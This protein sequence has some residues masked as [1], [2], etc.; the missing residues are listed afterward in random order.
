MDEK[1]TFSNMVWRFF[2]RVGA[3]GIAFIVSI[4]LARVL[5]PD[6]YGT[7]A[8]VTVIISIL[9]VFVDS[10]FGTSLIQKKYVN[11]LDYSSVFYFNILSCTIIYLF[12]FF[13]A[14]FISRIYN[15]ENLILIIRVMS[16]LLIISGIKNIQQAYIT[17]NMMFKKFFFA[18]LGGT[19]FAGIIGIMLAINGAGVWAL[20]IQMLSN[21]VV[22]TI[23]LWFTVGW[24]PCRQFSFQ[25]IKEL[26]RYSGSILVALLIARITDLLNQPLI[27][28]FYSNSDLAYYNQGYRIINIITENVNTAMES[29]LFP[30]IS[31]VQDNRERVKLITK[32]SVKMSCYV[33]MPMMMGIAVCGKAMISLLFTEK[34]LPCV[35]YMYVFC[36]L[37]AIYPINIANLNVPKALGISEI[38]IKYQ[39]IKSVISISILLLSLRFG[40]F[41]VAIGVLISFLLS[42]AVSAWPNREL[43]N[44]S[45]INEIQD[46][47]PII[48]LTVSMGAIVYLIGM[49]QFHLIIILIMQISMG[50]IV[51]MA[52]SKILNIDSYA[53]IKDLLKHLFN[54]KLKL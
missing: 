25:R 49:L 44:Y 34:W 5:S 23:I 32:K 28:L 1:K 38:L 42:T 36:V 53:I 47:I 7:V 10:G 12:I 31:R 30:T 46:V 20:I 8:I 39:L 40:V 51:Y 16:I 48:G 9:D 41:A 27:G 19:I 18:T 33:I 4:V 43:I 14:P 52:G 21:T 54:R 2:E 15:N 35:P 11:E 37:F 13:A 6:D 29:V 17:R 45:L 22:D 3:K 24:R 50:V 26:F